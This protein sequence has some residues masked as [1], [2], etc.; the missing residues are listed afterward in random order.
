MES[1]SGGQRSLYQPF[2]WRPILRRHHRDLDNYANLQKANGLDYVV[3]VSN[4]GGS[5]TSDPATLTVTPVIYV[6]NFKTERTKWLLTG[7]RL[8]GRR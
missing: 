6:E 3:E 7:H 8:G 5:S 2:Q 1:W 4:G